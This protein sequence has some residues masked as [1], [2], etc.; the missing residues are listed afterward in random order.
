[1]H[2][3][4]WVSMGSISQAAE[5]IREPMT[6]GHINTLKEGLQISRLALKAGQAC[7]VLDLEPIICREGLVGV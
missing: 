5:A 2:H 4:F 6:P 7:E 3:E 1:M